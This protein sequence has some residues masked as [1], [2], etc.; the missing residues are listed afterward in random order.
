MEFHNEKPKCTFAVPDKITVRQQLAYYSAAASVEKSLFLEHSW[1]AAKQLIIPQ[2]WKC[3]IM[4]EL[5]AS[6]DDLTSPQVADVILW[7]GMKIREHLSEYES[8]PKN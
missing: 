5:N 3:E 8:V 1:E 6:L 7:A 4:P 2:S